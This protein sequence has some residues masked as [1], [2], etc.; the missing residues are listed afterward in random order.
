MDEQE[1]KEKL[2]LV[3]ADV[4]ETIKKASPDMKEV[5]LRMY[6]GAGDGIE[7]KAKQ[8][9][10][11]A[12]AAIAQHGGAVQSWLP[13]CPLPTPLARTS[14]FFP[15]AHQKLKDRVYIEKMVITETAWGFLTF[16]GPKLSTFDEDALYAVLALL[17]GSKERE[18]IPAGDTEAY[19]YRG[20]LAPLLKLMGLKDAGLNRSRVKDSLMRLLTSAVEIAVYER[21]HERSGKKRKVAKYA[22]KNILSFYEW[23]ESGPKPRLVITVNPF[24]REFYLQERVTPL[25]VLRRAELKSPISKA[26]YRFI[27]SHRNPKWGPAHYLTLA[28][29]LNLDLDQPER[30]LRRQIKTAIQDLTTRNILTDESKF[31]GKDLVVL[32]RHVSTNLKYAPR[33]KSK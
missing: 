29:S 31:E 4:Q 30:Q 24:F 19:S 16:T 28:K 13:C 9:A 18:T 23:D 3:P 15:T 25:D 27:Q 22:A 5:F 1:F 12:H 7:A 2:A 14:P 20:P 11:G 32:C 33:I 10:Q 21:T 26:L 6:L 17:D 8:S